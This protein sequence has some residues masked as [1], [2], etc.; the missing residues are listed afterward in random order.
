M[1]KDPT[2]DKFTWKIILRTLLFTRN[3]PTRDVFLGIL[4]LL[5]DSKCPKYGCQ[6]TA[7]LITFKNSIFCEVTSALLIVSFLN[8]LLK[9]SC[10]NKGDIFN[11]KIWKEIG[12]SNFYALSFMALLGHTPRS[13][14]KIAYNS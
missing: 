6:E 1:K 11:S 4:L 7:D 8:F 10:Y 12:Y 13:P 14:G 5:K 3:G 2:K 9:S